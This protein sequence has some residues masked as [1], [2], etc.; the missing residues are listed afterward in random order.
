MLVGVQN[1]SRSW[2]EHIYI[3]KKHPNSILEYRFFFVSENRFPLDIAIMFPPS[4]SDKSVKSMK[5]FTKSLVNSFDI[6][7]TGTRFSFAVFADDVHSPLTF[8]SLE[9]K[10]ISRDNVETVLDG[11]KM[12]GSV[13]RLDKG[14]QWVDQ[15]IFNEY[16]GMR[17][18]VLKV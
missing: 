18:M 1:K 14:L 17:P 10:R 15:E 6:S 5:T 3:R 12:T 13:N 4:S 7:P 11:M 16:N 2:K 8:S 9:G